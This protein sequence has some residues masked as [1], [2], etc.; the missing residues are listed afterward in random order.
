MT[1]TMVMPSHVTAQIEK[2]A[3]LELETAGV[4]IAAII[5][6]P[7]GNFRLL[8]EDVIWVEDAAYVRRE[9]NGLS[10]ASHGYVQALGEA[11]R[12]GAMALWFHTHPGED[13]IPLPSTHDQQVDKDI[14]DLFR[15]RTNSLFYGTVIASPRAEG[16]VLTGTLQRERQSTILIDRFWLVGSRWRLFQAY[17]ADIKPIDPIFDRNVRAF[18]SAIQ[19]TL[20]QLHVGIVGCGGTGSAIAEQLVRLGIRELLLIDPDTL[21]LSNTTRVYGSVPARVGEPKVKVLHDHLTAIA[22]DLSCAILASTINRESSAKTL[23][24]CDL[25]FGC[26]DDN[27]GRLVLSRIATFLLT[28]VIDVGVLLSSDDNQIL[29]GIDGRV[30]VM[31]PG[32]AC[33]VCRDRVNLALAAAELLTP[34]ERRARTDDGYAPALPGVEPAVVAFT[35]AVA[36]AA[37]NELLERLLGYGSEPRPT[38]IL[39][40]LHEREI[41]T[42][43]AQPRLGHYCH[44]SQNFVGR[45]NVAPFLGQVWQ[46]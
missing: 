6:T 7:T 43:I 2:A 40:R 13:A 27:A 26:T 34:E 23:T 36:A 14:A 10:I 17:S 19:N 38:E 9:A 5:Q 15:L 33:L 37:V 21:S 4:L 30:T 45:G 42:N 31:A 3:R 28:P 46:A 8:V 44:P 25:V 16:I 35:T 39:L 20:R 41:S 12:R 24:D 32:D 29:I 18:G 11:E 1:T 22:P